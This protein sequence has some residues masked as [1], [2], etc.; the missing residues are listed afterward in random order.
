MDTVQS[1]LQEQYHHL[2]HKRNGEIHSVKAVLWWDDRVGVAI[3]MQLYEDMPDKVSLLFTRQEETWLNWAREFTTKHS[4]MLKDTTYGIVIDRKGKWDFIGKHNDF[5]SDEFDKKAC[6][7]LRSYWFTSVPWWSSDT[8]HLANHINAFNISCWY[9][10]PHT[11]EEYVVLDEARN[12]YEALKHLI[13]NFN[14]KLPIAKKK[15]Y[16]TPTYSKGWWKQYE[17]TKTKQDPLLSTDL[18]ISEQYL[19]YNLSAPQIFSRN[20]EICSQLKP[21]DIKINNDTVFIDANMNYLANLWKENIL[22]LPTSQVSSSAYI[23]SCTAKIV[24]ISWD[25]WWYMASEA[26]LITLVICWT[27]AKTTYEMKVDKGDMLCILSYSKARELRRA[28]NFEGI[29]SIPAK[30]SETLSAD[31]AAKEKKLIEEKTKKQKTEEPKQAA[32][33]DQSDLYPKRTPEE[34]SQWLLRNKIPAYSMSDWKKVS[35]YWENRVICNMDSWDFAVVENREKLSI[36]GKMQEHKRWSWVYR[37]VTKWHVISKRNGQKKT[38]I[39]FKWWDAIIM[40]NEAD[41]DRL[42]L[43]Y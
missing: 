9:Y 21:V 35:C 34:Y 1:A 42:P 17:Q 15:T 38:W 33:V 39:S 11:T 31:E 24:K 28:L 5:C 25:N 6:D 32:L 14:E 19:E 18:K 23:K 22:L 10:N 2:I 27:Y 41:F 29:S 13:Q 8:R 20:R 7:I 12:T 43:L 36:A 4:D 37:A 26:W 30:I 3:A 16:T 40:I